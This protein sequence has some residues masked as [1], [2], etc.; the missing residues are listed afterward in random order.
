MAKRATDNY[1]IAVQPRG[2]ITPAD[3]PRPV[4]CRVRWNLDLRWI[5]IEDAWAIAWTK[6]EVCV[7]WFTPSMP[8]PSVHWLP[9]ADVRTR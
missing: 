9:A 2:S 6:T 8:N 3:P 7:Y 4:R 5:T 1:L